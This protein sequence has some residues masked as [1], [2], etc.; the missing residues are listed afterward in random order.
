MKEENKE[1]KE[2]GLM[3]KNF[4]YLYNVTNLNFPSSFSLNILWIVYPATMPIPILKNI[5]FP[6]DKSK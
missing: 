2:T 3:I 1:V 5:I 6:G 4:S